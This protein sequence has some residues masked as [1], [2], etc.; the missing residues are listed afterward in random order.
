[1]R[2]LLTPA[3]LALLAACGGDDDLWIARVDDAVISVSEL[4]RAVDLRLQE[5]PELEREETI[6]HELSRLLRE[7]VILNRA[8]ELGAEV[9]PEDA[10]ERV[11]E[12]HG[13][14]FRR[15]DAEFLAEVQREMLLERTRLLDLANRIRIQE[16]AL[17]HYFESHR[18]RYQ[19]PERVTIRQIV[20]ESA[21]RAKRLLQRLRSG[22]DFA[23]LASESSL[24]PEASEGGLLPPYARGEMPEVFERA[25]SLKP[26]EISEVLESPYGFHILRLEERIPENEPVLDD[27]RE[28]VRFELEREQL[29]ELERGWLRELRRRA[30][31]QLNETLLETL[32]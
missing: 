8:R 26:G 1:M 5:D 14:A 27:V 23:T 10:E 3:L 30:N 4:Q 9:T 13:Q 15:M 31:I 28:R 2:R 12:L 24:A 32:R 18:E 25:F 17:V 6:N 20:V 7:R 19:T 22:E 16:S 21:D 11:R 29:A